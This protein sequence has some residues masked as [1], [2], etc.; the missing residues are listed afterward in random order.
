[1]E[2]T[3]SSSVGWYVAF[4]AAHEAAHV[5]AAAIVG[6]LDGAGGYMNIARALFGRH[7][8]LPALALADRSEVLFVQH[9]A[10]I[11]S[12]VL[13]VGAYAL[14]R[15]NVDDKHAKGCRSDAAA[16]MVL[17]AIVTALEALTSDLLRARPGESHFSPFADKAMQTS[18]FF[19]GNFGEGGEERGLA[20]GNTR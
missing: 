2:V 14:T 12:V 8:Y 10:W 6:R 9:F 19:C 17:A 20:R 7:V 13:A 1:M 18:L 3:A 15:T 5:A 4:G 11:C 16:A